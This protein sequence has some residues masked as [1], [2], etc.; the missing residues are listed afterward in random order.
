MVDN[1]PL[2][3]STACGFGTADPS[4]YDTDDD[5]ADDDDDDI[6]YD[7]DDVTD[8]FRSWCGWFR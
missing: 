7:D 8:D 2:N 3:Y 6:V 4:A 5:D 1:R